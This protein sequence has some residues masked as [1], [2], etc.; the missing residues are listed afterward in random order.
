MKEKSWVQLMEEKNVAAAELVFAGSY[1]F[2]VKAFCSGCRLR[3]GVDRY[4]S[5]S[6]IVSLVGTDKITMVD[7][8]RRSIEKRSVRAWQR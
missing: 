3:D 7:D 4:G 2:V 6:S 5:V 8:R 1:R